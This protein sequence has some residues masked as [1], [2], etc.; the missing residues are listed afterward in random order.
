[1]PSSISLTLAIED[2]GGGQPSLFNLCSGV[3]Q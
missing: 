2:L 3:Q 1:V